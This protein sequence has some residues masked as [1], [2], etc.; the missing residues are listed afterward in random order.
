M[1]RDVM[2]LKMLHDECCP[3]VGQLVPEVTRPPSCVSLDAD[4]Y[5]EYAPELG[6][7][8]EHWHGGVLVHK[9]RSGCIACLARH[10]IHRFQN[11]HVTILQVD[12]DVP[13]ALNGL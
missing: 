8:H 6:N 1:R 4:G 12:S 9:H 3:V 2:G 10:K 13:T 5:A 7:V 11:V